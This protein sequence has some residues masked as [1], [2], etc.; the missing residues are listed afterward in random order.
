M[1]GII[2]L[3]ILIIIIALILLFWNPWKKPDIPQQTSNYFSPSI[4]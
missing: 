3:L 2:V 4:I 1:N